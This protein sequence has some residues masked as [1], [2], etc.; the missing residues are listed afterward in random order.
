MNIKKNIVT[1][2]FL[3]FIG[4]L[5]ILLFALPKSDYSQN[6]KRVLADFPEVSFESITSGEFSTGIDTYTAEQ[7]TFRDFVVAITLNH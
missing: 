4:V 5:A 1:F 3:A 7:F 6:E 2:I